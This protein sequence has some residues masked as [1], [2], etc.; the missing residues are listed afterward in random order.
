MTHAEIEVTAELVR[1]LLRDQHPDLADYPVRLG[2]RGWDN[3]LWRLGDDLGPVALGD[4]G[5][6][7]AAAQG[8][9]L[10][11]RPRSSPPA[12]GSRSATSRRALRPFPRPWIVTTWVPGTPA[13]HAPVTRA[14]EAATAL[15]AFLT[16]LH[17]PAPEHAPA[18]RDRGGRWP[19]TPRVSSSN[20]PR[21]PSWDSSP[22]LT[23]S[24]RSGKTPPRPAAPVRHCGSTAACIRPTSSPPTAPS[25]A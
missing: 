8:A 2:A 17:R 12:A 14:A 3:Q 5:R 16:A 6:G 22:T 10:A 21:P 23:P 18:S 13:D 25:A 7:R 9:H 20:S 15:A 1:D 19:T 24:A 4:A 11:A